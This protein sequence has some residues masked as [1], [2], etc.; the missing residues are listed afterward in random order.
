[1]EKDAPRPHRWI[2]FALLGLAL[3][4]S[5]TWAGWELIKTSPL[6][7]MAILVLYE[8]LIWM[9][10]IAKTTLNRLSNTWAERLATNLDSFAQR[11]LSRYP[12]VY[13]RAVKAQMSFIENKGLLTVGDYTLQLP[14]VYVPVDLEPRTP[15]NF[16]RGL[17]PD[18]MEAAK[19]RALTD[20]TSLSL[21]DGLPLVVV[22][23]PGSGKTTLLR[24][25]ALDLATGNKVVKRGR[26]ALQS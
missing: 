14:D 8:A 13:R 7:S 18:A 23:P 12:R 26:R 16:T 1:M 4:A 25:L 3:P 2:A 15:Q 11:R 6:L 24:K 5:A 20:W 17:L 10:T 21:E 19:A 22:G 9:G